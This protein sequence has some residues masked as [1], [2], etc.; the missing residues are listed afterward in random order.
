MPDDLGFAGFKILH[1]LNDPDRFDEVLSFLGASYFRAL[2]AD[3]HYGLS[4]RGLA[5][6]TG[7]T[8]KGEEFP[9]F[10]KFWLVDPGKGGSRMVIYA[11]LDSPSVTGA[12]KFVLKPGNTTKISV[13]ETLYTRKAIDK[14]GIA[15]LTSMFTWGENSLSRLQDYR[16]EAHDSDG[17]L[18]ASEDGEWLWRPLVDPQKLWMHQYDANHVRGFGLMQRDRN[19]DHY[20]DLGLEYEK[21]PSAWIE[22]K[23][24]WGDGHL[25]LVEIPS[26][27]EM[28]DNIALYWVPKDKVKADETLH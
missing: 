14:L 1:T 9:R 18:I 3:Q 19:F 12:Y 25:E 5:I 2:G 24:D 22:P 16:P 7:N 11:L 6:D 28:N 26:D 20:Q 27:S 4:A 8:S 21:R 17:L 13:E 23:G 15:P 10:T